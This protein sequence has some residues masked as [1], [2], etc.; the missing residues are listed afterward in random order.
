MPKSLRASGPN[1][2]LHLISPDGAHTLCGRLRHS[3]NCK[4]D[5]DPPDECLC[6]QCVK[7]R[8]PRSSG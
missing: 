2:A 6:K 8:G 4:G 1:Y 5:D 3:V 7:V